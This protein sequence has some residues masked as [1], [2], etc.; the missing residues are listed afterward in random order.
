MALKIKE[1]G[2]SKR[3]I[4]I[5]LNYLGAT[6]LQIMKLTEAERY[7]MRAKQYVDTIGTVSLKKETYKKPSHSIFL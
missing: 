4:A 3:D 1:E 2:G 5:S 6:Y 7:L